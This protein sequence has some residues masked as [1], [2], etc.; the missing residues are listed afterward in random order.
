MK[1]TGLQPTACF[2]ILLE[3]FSHLFQLPF[4]PERATKCHPVMSKS[5]LSPV[6]VGF[7]CA[8]AAGDG[9][10]SGPCGVGVDWQ[11]DSRSCKQWT[12]PPLLFLCCSLHSH[13]R[14]KKQNKNRT[15]PGTNAAVRCVKH[16]LEISAGSFSARFVK[17]FKQSKTW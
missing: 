6:P 14:L 11:M 13:F 8:A 9:G 17:M 12:Q 1:S 3:L 4:V 5:W 10:E 7:V 2:S 16:S 15:S